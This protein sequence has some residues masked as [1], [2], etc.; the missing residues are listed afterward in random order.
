MEHSVASTCS[1]PFYAALKNKIQ[2]TE[3]VCIPQWDVPLCSLQVSYVSLFS[4][5]ETSSFLFSASGGCQEYYLPSY[6][7][8]SLRHLTTKGNCAHFVIILNPSILETLSRLS[9]NHPDVGPSLNLSQLKIKD[10]G[11][12][13]GEYSAG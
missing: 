3:A 8:C 5:Q 9:C 2:N 6:S 11:E 12:L 4:G 7:L 13:L 10:Y 1:F